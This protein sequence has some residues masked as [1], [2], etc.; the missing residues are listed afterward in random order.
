M[1]FKMILASIFI[2][3][4]FLLSLI[5]SFACPTSLLD[6]DNAPAV[7][8]TTDFQ[9]DRFKIK[10]SSPVLPV[11][12]NS[13]HQNKNDDQKS[14]NLYTKRFMNRKRSMNKFEEASRRTTFAAMLPK[15]YVPPSGSSP[16]HNVYPN[17]V[18]FFC[19]FSAET[20]QP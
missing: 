6:H 7:S 16:C 10:K 8:K 14:S 4:F 5:V 17:S 19:D 2:S 20:R 1:G 3:I 13:N 18:A 12:L 15:G 11:F 9:A